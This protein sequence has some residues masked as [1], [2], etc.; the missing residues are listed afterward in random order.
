MEQ[1]IYQTIFIT[2][3]VV[4]AVTFVLQ[5]LAL[6]AR[7]GLQY[8]WLLVIIAAGLVSW[9]VGKRMRAEPWFAKLQ[10]RKKK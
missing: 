7:S 6:R 1:K 5:V 2:L 8:V 3:I 4:L 10:A 9:A